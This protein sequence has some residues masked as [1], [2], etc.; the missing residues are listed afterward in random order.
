MIG[1]VERLNFRP[2]VDHWKAKGLDYSPILYQPDVPADAPRHCVTAQDHGLKDA[3]DNELIAQCANALERGTPV[4]LRLPD[5]K[6]EPD[7]GD[8]ARLRGD[9]PVRRGG[10]ART[11]RSR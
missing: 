8:D 6:R 4:S 1:R 9:A 5:S 10:A 11:T 3:L 7:G 2:A